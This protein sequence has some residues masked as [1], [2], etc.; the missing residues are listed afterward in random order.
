KCLLETIEDDILFDVLVAAD[1]LSLIELIKYIEEYHELSE[2]NQDDFTELRERLKELLPLIRFY[3]ISGSE[4]Y[5]YVRPYKK[6]LDHDFRMKLKKFYIDETLEAPQD[7]LPYRSPVSKIIHSSQLEF[8]ATWIDNK[9]LVENFNELITYKFRLLLR[10]SRDGMGIEKFH[11]LCNNKGA[12]LVL[13][14]ID[15]PRKIIG[16]YNP[17]PWQSSGRWKC[18]NKSFIF[19]FKNRKNVNDYILAN[20]SHS[21]SAINDGNKHSRFVGFGD[22]AWF[23]NRYSKSSYDKTIIETNNYNVEDYEVFQ[24]IAN[25]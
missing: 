25:E 24:V 11:E 4:Y 8:I 1:E 18:T 13:I 14:Q 12:T 20:V 15:G 23:A 19:S 9:E 3:T 16:G 22:M 2:W 7:A 17:L 21:F 10:G 5:Q 6:V